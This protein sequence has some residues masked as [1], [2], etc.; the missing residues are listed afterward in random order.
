MFS[1]VIVLCAARL[2]VAGPGPL[3]T[4][5]Q[6]E[7]C[8][9]SPDHLLCPRASSQ[10][11]GRGHSESSLELSTGEISQCLV[12]VYSRLCEIIEGR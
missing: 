2:L 9:L 1:S 8:V 5:A 12:D 11:G 10:Q 3:L 6:A 7:Y 4:A